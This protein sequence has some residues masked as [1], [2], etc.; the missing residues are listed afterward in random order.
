MAQVLPFNGFYTGNSEKN[1]SRT[2]VNYMPIKHDSGALSE[3]TL[4]STFGIDDAIAL[5]DPFIYSNPTVWSASDAESLAFIITAREVSP[6]INNGYLISTDG[7]S[8]IESVRVFIDTA[9]GTE[10][11]SSAS[12][13]NHLGFAINTASRGLIVGVDSSM[14]AFPTSPLPIGVFAGDIAYL[15]GRFLVSSRYDSTVG[16]NNA[17][18]YSDINDPSTIDPLGY[19]SDD[20]QT[21][22]TIG[23]HVSKNRLFLF[24]KNSYS[25]WVN[26]PDVN[27]PFSIQK[28][29]G[30]D[31]GLMNSAAKT[32]LG[33]ILYFIGISKGKA[34]LWA[35]NGSAS[36]IG[37]EYV[38]YQLESAQSVSMFSFADNGRAL[39]AIKIQGA[40]NKDFFYDIKS[41]EFHSRST[42]GDVND[43]SWSVFGVGGIRSAEGE[44]QVIFSKDKNTDDGLSISVSNSSIGTEF[45]AQVE[46]ECITSPFNSDG[47]TNNVRELAFQADIDYSSLTPVTLPDLSLS[48]SENFGKTFETE[49]LEAFD[50]DGENT[51]I[52]RYMNIGFFRQAFVFKLKTDTIYPHKILKMLTRL[53]KGFRQI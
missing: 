5:D 8:V 25:I 24:S 17:V 48:V 51:K 36:N 22:E 15:G 21:S 27:L 3:Y 28:G 47:V 43:L 11:L 1:S 6:G 53:E 19:F 33:G 35:L 30:G 13:S 34:S 29:S 45:G 37:N 20:N 14:V 40:S 49:R 23:I 12:S 10:V 18:Y 2:C 50:A 32:E 42:L 44:R 31:V 9:S 7:A 16:Q 52:L 38:D 4:E 39:I 26:T 41:G 46:R